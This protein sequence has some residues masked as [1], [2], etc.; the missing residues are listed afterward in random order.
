VLR[1][2][3]G[4][5]TLQFHLFKRLPEELRLKN[6]ISVNH[7]PGSSRP[8]SKTQRKFIA[9]GD[10]C[11]NHIHLTIMPTNYICD[12]L[13]GSRKPLALFILT[14]TSGF[15]IKR[16]T[17]LN[18]LVPEIDELQEHEKI[19]LT[20]TTP[21]QIRSFTVIMNL[22]PGAR[23]V[24]YIGIRRTI[25]SCSGKT[26]ECLPTNFRQRLYSCGRTMAGLLSR[27]KMQRNLL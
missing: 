7:K 5:S 2:L 4:N 25:S 3:S 26:S 23:R 27:S 14:Y 10:V 21:F 19:L 8:I 13:H 20:S 18:H 1:Y 6:G 11:P 24:R 16:D 9:P 17:C 22:W 15:S 12:I